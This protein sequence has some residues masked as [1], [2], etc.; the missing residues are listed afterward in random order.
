MAFTSNNY[1]QLSLSDRLMTLNDKEREILKDSWAEHFSQ[2]IFPRIDESLFAD[3]YSRDSV[4]PS[5]PVN[6]TVGAL[7]LQAIFDLTDEELVQAI[8]FDVRYQTALRTTSALTQPISTRTLNRFRRRCLDAANRTGANPLSACIEEL[9]GALDEFLGSDFPGKRLDAEE[10]RRRITKD[11]EESA[12]SKNMI[13]DPAIYRVG[14]LPARSDHRFYAGEKEAEEGQSSFVLSLNGLWK[15]RYDTSPLAAPDD[16]AKP[17]YSCENWADIRVPGHIQLQGYSTPAYVNYQYPWDGKEK[18]QPGQIPTAFNPTGSYVKTFVLPKDF[19]GR[20][21]RIRFDGAES[22]YALWCNGSFVGYH[23]DSFTPA[24]FDLTPHLL[25]GENKLGVQVYQWTS[26]S[27]LEDQDMFRFSGIFRDVTLYAV[28]AM[29]VEDLKVRTLLDDFCQDAQLQVNLQLTLD[30]G[31]SGT[32]LWELSRKGKITASGE[33]SAGEDVKIRAEISAPALWSAEKPNLYDLCLTLRNAKGNCVEYLKEEVGF[34]RFELKNGLLCLNGK[35]ITFHGVNRHEFTDRAGRAGMTTE[36]IRR[37]LVIMKQNNIN[38]IRTSHYPNDSRLYRLCDEMGLYLIAENNMETHGTWDAAL[39]FGAEAD[40]LPGDKKEWE[41]ALLQRVRSCYERDK[42]HPSILIWSLGNE[43]YGGSVIHEMAETFRALDPDR[44]VHYEGIFHDR[45]YPDTSDMESQMYPPADAIAA[46]LQEHPEKPFICCEYSHS[47]GNS[48]GG[49]F[50]YTDLEETNPRYQGG[51]IWDFCDQS[52]A[53]RDEWG[54]PYEAYGGDFGERPCDYTFSGNGIVAGD[55]YEYPKLQEIRYCYQNLRIAIDEAHFTVRNRYLFT[56]ASD[57]ACR[58]RLEKDGATILEKPVLVNVPPLAE[59]T[60][61]LPFALPKDPGEYTVTVSFVLREKTSYAE[62]GYEV[63]FGQ[64]VFAVEPER[65]Q[66]KIYTKEALSHFTTV[67]GSYNFGA[68]TP[69]TSA[70]VSRLNG[71]GLQ[72]FRYAGKEYMVNTP[73]PYFW[74]APTDNDRGNHMGARLGIWR[75]CSDYADVLPG[76][77]VPEHYLEEVRSNPSVTEREGELSIR[78][79]YYLPTKEQNPL[80]V[81]Y[82]LCA[83]GSVRITMDWTP[84]PDLPEMP[85]FGMLFVLPMEL[86]QLTFYGNGPKECYCDRERGAK[87]GIWHTTVTENMT[88]YLIPQECGNR[89]AVRWA[90]LTDEAGRGL[91][92][93]FEEGTAIDTKGARG[94]GAQGGMEFSALPWTPAEIES[95]AHHTELPRRHHTIVRVNLMQMGVAG[96]DSWGALPHKEF[97]VPSKTTPLHFVF[98]I[99][100]IG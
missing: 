47:M 6:V 67:R 89:T 68:R 97:L 77:L 62:A 37:D 69:D 100:G 23:E 96:D 19:V 95:A 4:A 20:P 38:A 76:N 48:N 82:T 80:P 94:N 54:I 60:Y 56:P 83:D 74:R 49:L 91:L 32:V 24:E 70:L 5:N 85:A 73:R 8:L 29:H 13:A 79:V 92:F 55:R 34:R 25:P 84:D 71:N 27:W 31:A 57:F 81:T 11:R 36:Q 88:R 61:D 2:R 30:E 51:F 15:F 35:R 66:E 65:K 59:K 10:I 45:T 78:Q 93:T 87:L 3:L 12:F 42:N 52:L 21:V 99:R 26:G 28:P 14:C 86:E 40:I 16:F 44:P 39:R 53:M 41:G 63:A 72:S 1:Q 17:G 22:G 64:R 58:V 46:F 18:I 98:R 7:I 90:K 50:K 9:Y 33:V 43:S 75:N